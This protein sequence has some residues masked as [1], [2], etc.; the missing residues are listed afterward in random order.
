M[1]TSKMKIEELKEI[2]EKELNY[3]YISE[4]SIDQ[5][6]RFIYNFFG[7]LTL[8]K[9]EGITKEDIEGFINNLYTSQ[10]VYFSGNIIKE[11]MFSFITE[12]ILNFCP[13]PFFW[14]I[15]LEEYMKKWEKIYFPS[16][17]S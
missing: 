1:D 10:S 16:L 3:N 2:I 12:E 6:S 15:P 7:I 13:S 14:N 11:D 9:K 5:Y 8:Y 17:K 4:L